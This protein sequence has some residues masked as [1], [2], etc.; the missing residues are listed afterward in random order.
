MGE[1]CVKVD[2]ARLAARLSGS[3]VIV[4]EAQTHFWLIQHGFSY[5]GGSWYCERAAL[6]HL[7]PGELVE[8]VKIEEADGVA[9]VKHETPKAAPEAPM[10]GKGS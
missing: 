6:R 4:T 3:G 7:L 1:I 8:T 10:P 9:F 5:R 2:A